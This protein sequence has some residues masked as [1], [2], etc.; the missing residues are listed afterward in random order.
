MSQRQDSSLLHYRA[1]IRECGFHRAIEIAAG[2]VDD[3]RDQLGRKLDRQSAVRFAFLVAGFVLGILVC[4]MKGCTVVGHQRVEGWPQ[5][6][7]VEHHV[8]H[9]DMR[10][11][12]QQYAPFGSPVEACA[13]FFFDRGECHV[14]FS[15]DFPP[16]QW[17]KD[18]EYLHCQG[19]GHVGDNSMRDFLA[20]WRNK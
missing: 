17:I 20:R 18:H 1:L 3:L 7:V 4:A 19:F 6:K 9:K 10:D 2:D 11:V 5:L 14:W 8:P 16:Q 15:A 13:Q 12:C